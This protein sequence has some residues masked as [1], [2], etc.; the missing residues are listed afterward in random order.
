MKLGRDDESYRLL[1]PLAAG[2][3]ETADLYAMAAV[4]AQGAAA[5][6]DSEGYYQ[7]AVVLRPDDPALLTN[8]GI[9]KLARGDTTAG[10]DTLNRAA[11]LEGDDKKAL[12][13][14]FSSLLQKRTSTRPRPWPGTPS[15][16]IPIAPGAGRWT[17]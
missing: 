5:M 12:L 13:L 7:K 9:V 16:N 1:R 3:G 17:A 6:A 11:E 4:A 14:L 15:G 8:L 10:E 2:D